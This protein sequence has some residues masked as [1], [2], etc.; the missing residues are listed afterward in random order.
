MTNLRP[1][2]TQPVFVICTSCGFTSRLSSMPASPKNGCPSCSAK[3]SIKAPR[4]R[5]ENR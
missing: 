2:K 3:L 5:I 4:P 1:S